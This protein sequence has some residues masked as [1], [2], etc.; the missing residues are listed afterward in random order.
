[1]LKF[2]TLHLRLS[3]RGVIAPAALMLLLIIGAAEALARTP[4]VEDRLPMPALPDHYELGPKIFLADRLYH[5]NHRIDPASGGIDPA[6]PGTTDSGLHPTSRGI[7]CFFIGS[8]VIG[9][10]VIPEDFMT[11]YRQTTG[12]P[13][14]CFN[15]GLDTLT[16]TGARNLTEILVRRYHPKLILF[17]VHFLYFTTS[18]ADKFDLDTDWARAQLGEPGLA[19]WL[20]SNLISYRY[21]LTAAQTPK[22]LNE[23]RILSAVFSPYGYYPSDAIVDPHNENRMKPQ[24][25]P[26]FFT[27]L[28]TLNLAGHRPAL[29]ALLA[30]DTGSTQLAMVDVPLSPTT[31]RALVHFGYDYQGYLDLIAQ[32][33]RAHGVTFIPASPS[34]LIPDDGFQDEIHMN[35]SGASLFSGW[36][37]QQVGRLAQQGAIQGLAH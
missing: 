13:I 27:V 36:L 25:D 30:T 16:F 29:D 12:Q 10:G 1:M 17:G 32:E 37:G 19:G 9:R 3:A 21:A 5:A 2:G 11:A 33:A 34:G 28:D 6:S 7:D 14:T 35:T 18:D 22:D 4:A 15:F 31:A 26:D 24:D 20:E 23:T 8:S